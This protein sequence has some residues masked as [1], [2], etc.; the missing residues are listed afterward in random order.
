MTM[1]EE[2]ERQAIRE[3]TREGMLEV[4][5]LLGVDISDAEAVKEMQ[6]DM[7]WLRQ[8]RLASENMPKYIKRAT[9]GGSA[10]IVVYALWYWLGQHLL[11]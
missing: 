8:G 6:K 2:Q 3:S 11:K 10:T 4:L 5:L 7:H 1:G 9:I